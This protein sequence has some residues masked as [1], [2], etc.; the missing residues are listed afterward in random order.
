[1]LNLEIEGGRMCGIERKTLN[2]SM[3]VIQIPIWIYKMSNPPLYE[4]HKWSKFQGK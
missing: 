2:N 1:M 3:E 4:K